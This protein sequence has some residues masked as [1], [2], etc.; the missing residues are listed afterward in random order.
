M[1]D[2]FYIGDNTELKEKYP[3]SKQID[4]ADSIKSNTA[5]YWLVESNTS[6]TDWEIFEFKPDQYTVTF[7]H[8]WKWNDENYGGVV[9]VPKTGGDDTVFHNKIVC[10]K[11]FDILL[12]E[13]P[14]EYFENNPHSSHVWCVD[15]QYVLGDDINWAPGNFEPELY[16]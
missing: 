3:F 6:I 4:N 16:P 10:K 7:E 11:Q 13:T 5:L 8:K 12:Q 14:G 2:I 15:P 9:L 1:Y